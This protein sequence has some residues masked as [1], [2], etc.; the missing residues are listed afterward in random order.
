MKRK[1]KERKKGPL[2]ARSHKREDSIVDFLSPHALPLEE[3]PAM[4]IMI[5]SDDPRGAFLGVL[6]PWF[7]KRINAPAHRSPDAEDTYLPT[8]GPIAKIGAAMYLAVLAYP[9]LNDDK[10][11]QKRDKFL[12]AVAH[13]MDGDYSGSWP[14]VEIKNVMAL[15]FRRIRSR[16]FRAAQHAWTIHFWSTWTSASLRPFW[17][18]EIPKVP[19]AGD[20]V[21]TRPKD[22]PWKKWCSAEGRGNDMHR[23]WG[24]S[25]PVL[26]LTVAMLRNATE[27]HLSNLHNLIISPSWLSPALLE[28]E[29]WRM[30]FGEHLEK[31]F[32]PTIAVRL[33]PAI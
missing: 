25:L 28:S 26:H 8:M 24:Q 15:C 12:E 20:I 32:D 30:T 19:S 27:D 17:K 14:S 11:R 9:D 33:L 1:Q 2:R 18:G 29:Y 7:R 31:S 3:P 10:D 6:G 13:W 16:R 4:E 5:R 22:I 23:V 21:G